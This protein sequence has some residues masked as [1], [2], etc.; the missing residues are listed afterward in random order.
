M[1][2][3]QVITALNIGLHVG[4]IK[5]AIREKLERTGVGFSCA[6]AVIEA[7]L[8]VQ[9]EEED[10]IDS[11]V[12]QEIN[13]ILTEA[14][15]LTLNQN[16]E[17]VEQPSIPEPLPSTC[18]DSELKTNKSLTLEEENRLLKEARLCK[19]CLD[20]EVGI[21]F[22]PCG[23]LATCVNCAPNLQDCPVCRCTIKAT[24]RAFLS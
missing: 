23:H 19:I 16:E 22:L 2:T 1:F 15:Q 5:Q 13:E 9:L 24:V 18:S 6:N 10:N 21:V 8:N 14:V 3:P 17:Q 7:A 4:R 12:S 20:S 11:R